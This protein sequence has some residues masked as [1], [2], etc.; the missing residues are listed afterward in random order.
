MKILLTGANGFIGSVIVE[1]LLRNGHEVV[2]CGRCP[3]HLPASARLQFVPMDLSTAGNVAR[4]KPVLDGVCA[5]VNC[6]GILRESAHGDFNRIHVDA[7]GALLA[8]CL[9]AGVAKFVQVSALGDSADGE[10]IASKH[11]FD[12]DLLRSGQAATVLRPSLVLSTRGSYGGTSLL[13]AM[14]ALPF[15]VF[16][17]ASGEQQVQPVLAEDLAETVLRCLPAGVAQGQVLEVVGPEVLSLRETLGLLRRWL[18]IPAPYWV[19]V[20]QPLVNLATWI[21]DRI[22][23]GPL[24]R[25]MGSMLDRGNTGSAGAHARTAEAT[26]FRA[27]P[28]REELDIAASFVQDRWHARLQ[29]LRPILWLTLVVIWIASGLAGLFASASDHAPILDALLVPRRMQ[30]DVVLASSLLDLV[31]GFALLLRWRPRVVLGLML[32]SVMAYTVLPGAMAGDLW[33]DPL[34]GLIKNFGLIGLLLVCLVI[35]DDR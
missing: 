8:A 3:K 26:G 27:R 23:A 25:T 2:A 21:G 14:A 5:V 18:H 20:P 30:G 1:T 4:W 34:G 19:R 10:F 35:E 22:N 31:L 32:V 9:D 7:P 24:G 33:M 29:G 12:D 6:A 15:V 17:P 28:V 16:L 11:R 13:R